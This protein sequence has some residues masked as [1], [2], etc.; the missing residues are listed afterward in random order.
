[1]RLLLRYYL[2][3]TAWNIVRLLAALA[4]CLR[5]NS[6]WPKKGRLC[7]E[8]F[9][10][11]FFI[12]CR[13]CLP[14]CAA[15]S[16]GRHYRNLHQFDR[17]LFRNGTQMNGISADMRAAPAER[18]ASPRCDVLESQL[19]AVDLRC[20]N[21]GIV[22][23]CGQGGIAIQAVAPPP[24]GPG[25]EL[26]V[27]I[28][29]VPVVATG[30]IVWV[31]EFHQAGIR[32]TAMPGM[33][34]ARFAEWLEQT[35]QTH[36]A[37]AE[38]MAT[39]PGP[40]ARH[41]PSMTQGPV[42][43]Q[44]ASPLASPLH[45]NPPAGHTPPPQDVNKV[46]AMDDPEPWRTTFAAAAVLSLVLMLLFWPLLRRTTSLLSVPALSQPPASVQQTQGPTSPPTAAQTSTTTS[47][48]QPPSVSPP[49]PHPT[50]PRPARHHFRRDEQGD[51][52]DEV[53]V[54]HFT[55]P[56]PPA[57]AREQQTLPPR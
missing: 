27:H 35:A 30:D 17:A 49:E 19:V 57:A 33:S 15:A 4:L 16:L 52:D 11:P 42:P 54:R 51:D 14:S 47:P 40:P 10:F 38:I 56:A 5:K 18:R 3:S 37:R 32:F 34:R 36:P 20:D 41:L 45:P 55:R 39:L 48:P 13:D 44:P 1:M 43:A 24:Q 22:L 9:L 23:N 12:L 6:I 28:P 50:R 25:H 7:G 46:L 29:D 21:G 26:L 53:I 31:N 2:F 8:K